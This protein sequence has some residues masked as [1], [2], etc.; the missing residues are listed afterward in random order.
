MHVAMLHTHAYM[1]LIN[2]IIE[3]TSGCSPARG[4]CICNGHNGMHGSSRLHALLHTYPTPSDIPAR[5]YRLSNSLLFILIK[6]HTLFRS[7]KRLKC[8]HKTLDTCLQLFVDSVTVHIVTRSLSMFLHK[9]VLTGIW[10][11]CT[12]STIHKSRCMSNL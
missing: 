11:L 3:L 7:I 8:P 6:M 5:T 4:A 9:K 12:S 1:Q 2:I 10:F